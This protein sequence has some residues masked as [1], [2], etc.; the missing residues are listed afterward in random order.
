MSLLEQDVYAKEAYVKPT[1]LRS[2]TDLEKLIGK[3]RCASLCAEYISKPQGKPT[4][5][6]Y[7]DKRPAFNS[8]TDEF[9]NIYI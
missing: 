6:P 9:K 1:Q 4:L 3:K 7:D 8:A 5:V 2:I